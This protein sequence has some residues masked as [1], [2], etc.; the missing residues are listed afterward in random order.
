MDGSKSSYQPACWLHYYDIHTILFTKYYI[1]CCIQQY[2]RIHFIGCSQVGSQVVVKYTPEYDLQNASNL[3]QSHIPSLLDSMPPGQLSR[4]VQAQSK[5]V[6]GYTSNDIQLKYTSE[7]TLNNA[8]NWTW[9]YTCSHICSYV[10]SHNAFE[11]TSKHALPYVSNCMTWYTPNLLHS[12]L[13]CLVS[14]GKTL[15]I[16]PAYMLPYMLL[17]I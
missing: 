11:H 6:P 5:Y 3:T 15:P 14:S 12:M 13:S 9:W 1:L 2:S 10:V 8:P 17:G 16:S 4:S 7:Q